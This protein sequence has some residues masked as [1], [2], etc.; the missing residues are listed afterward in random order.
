MSFTNGATPVTES[1]SSTVGGR[2]GVLGVAESGSDERLSPN[3]EVPPALAVKGLSKT[4]GGARALVEVDLNLWRGEVH[5]LVG[6]NGAG[7]ST[8]VKII[9][10]AVRPDAGHVELDGNVVA[11]R[12][13]HQRPLQHGLAFI[14]QASVLCRP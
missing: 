2:G 10:G 12:S 8:L 9:A 14:F 11:F 13:P 6:E 5:C 4:F 7:K 3:G 1:Y